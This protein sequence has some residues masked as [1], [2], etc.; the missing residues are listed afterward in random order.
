MSLKKDKKNAF[1][2]SALAVLS[3]SITGAVLNIWLPYLLS[4]DIH[5]VVAHPENL[6]QPANMLGLILLILLGLLS[7][8]AIGAYW[9]YHFFSEKYFEHGSPARWALFGFL[10]ALIIK[11]PD[12]VFPQRWWVL[13]IALK[14][15]G[16]LVAFFLARW[17]VPLRRG[18]E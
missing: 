15:L 8:T 9:L 10:F 4:G 16:L 13:Q 3:Y 12:W 2:L 5:T 11:T 14:S 7:L 17:I 18:I 6:S 1:F